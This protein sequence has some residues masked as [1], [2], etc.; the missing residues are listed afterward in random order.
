MKTLYY[1]KYSILINT[2]VWTLCYLIKTFI[3]WSITN[4]FQWL[5]DIPTYSREERML[6]LI[7][8][9]FYQFIC[10]SIISDKIDKKLK[11]PM[12]NDSDK[13]CE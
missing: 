3:I 10:I 11:G 12:E 2:L 4:P 9:L 1:L 13:I 8:Y 5:I 7:V 6:G